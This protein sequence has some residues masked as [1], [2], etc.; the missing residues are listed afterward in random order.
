[1]KKISVLLAII[2][3]IISSVGLAGCGDRERILKVYAPGE[4][5]DEDVLSGFEDW[6]YE[7]TG[8]SVTLQYKTFSTNEDAYT[9]IY[10]KHADYDLVCFSDYIVSR[11]R[12]ND[13][14]LPVDTEFIYGDDGEAGTVM[15]SI[16]EA[17]NSYEI[18]DGSVRYSAPYMWG[19]F[20]I[21]YRA[22]MANTLSFDNLSWDSLFKS[23]E[24]SGKRYMKNSIRD[25]YASA[26][27]VAS[28]DKLSK[29]SN[30]FTDYND[31]YRAELLKVIN[32]TS[33]SN[34]QAVENILKEQKKYLF[35]YESDDGKDDMIT[36]SPSAIMGLFWSCDAGYAMEDSRDLFYGV[37]K[38][39]ANVWVDAYVM[40]KYAGNTEAAQYFLKYLAR[41]VI[42]V[43]GDECDVPVLNRDYAGCSTPVQW[44]NDQTKDIMLQAKAAL[45]GGEY[46]KGEDEDVDY[47]V[48]FFSEATDD[49]F[50]Q[51][52]IDMLF[53]PEEVLN[54]CAVMTDSDKD[55]NINMAKMWIRVKAS[56]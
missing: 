42:K 26:S 53:P 13:L 4:Y 38:E 25:A 23:G 2:L 24:Y 49:R 11:L 45:E 40:P 43:D 17:M 22:D 5:I 56:K 41:G 54:R 9:E 18:G 21:M 47:Y 20:G 36:S 8:K 44:V 46:S 52:Y 28:K 10:R 27:I 32:D 34:M 15:G 50:A 48:E 1:M 30:G 33:E 39:G 31:A 35:A 37:P 14:L 12:K 6:Y 16:L 19:T 51:M 3:I 7:E 29:L 55:A